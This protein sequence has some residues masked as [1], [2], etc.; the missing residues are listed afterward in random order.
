MKYAVKITDTVGCYDVDTV[1]ITIVPLM[2]TD[3]EAPD[4]VCQNTGVK[5]RAVSTPGH[6]P[7]Y[8]W[9]LDGGT[10]AKGNLT[11]SIVAVWGTPGLKKV[12]VLAQSNGC[13]IPD[14]VYVY[15]RPAPQPFFQASSVY[16]CVGDTVSLNITKE[17]GFFYWK[18][19][20]KDLTDTAYVS[21]V[22]LAWNKSG[23]KK[24]VLGI[25]GDKKCPA[26]EFSRSIFV[27]D[28]PDATIT[29]KN[30]FCIGGVS[31]LS[32]KV[33]PD[34]IYDW[35]PV[36]YFLNNSTSEVQAEIPE[37]GYVTL[38][39]TDRWL[40]RCTTKDSIYANPKECC[41]IMTPDAFTPN[42]DGRN[43]MFKL[44]TPGTQKV[45][46]FM[47]ANRRGQVLYKSESRD[48]GWDGAYKGVAQDEDTYMFFIEYLCED[49]EI[50]TKKGTFHLIR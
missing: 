26:K 8:Y 39:V 30:D 40:T 4:T 35:R 13:E 6:K 9:D 41:D 12:Y 24:I 32:A 28:F 7:K 5:I 10:I 25:Q 11:D 44:I 20:E 34:Y 46:S 29:L 23:E 33:H 15:V 1:T 22:K 43:D 50:R 18:V 21:P 16:A 3:I 37:P 17:N 14:S 47:V 38:Q 2:Q 45:L 36:L 42:G 27:R 19:D 31:T 49:Q 48:G